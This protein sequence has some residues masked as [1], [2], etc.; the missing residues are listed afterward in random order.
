MDPR[1]K[2]MKGAFKICVPSHL[3]P[4]HHDETGRAREAPGMSRETGAGRVCHSQGSRGN[5]EAR[6]PLGPRGGWESQHRMNCED[7]EAVRS[8]VRE[9]KGN[10]HEQTSRDDDL[11]LLHARRTPG[12]VD[13]DVRPPSDQAPAAGLWASRVPLEDRIFPETK[14]KSVGCSSQ[15]GLPG[16]RVT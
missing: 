3:V 10:R 8:S 7:S 2:P 9:T 15:G 6:H 5:Q 4:L 11:V 12:L 13:V 16:G 14:C 1:C